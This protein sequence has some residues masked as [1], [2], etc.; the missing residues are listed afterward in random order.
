MLYIEYARKLPFTSGELVYMDDALPKPRLLAYTMY[1]F[2]FVFL[3]TSTAQCMNFARF[4]LAASKAEYRFGY[5]ELDNQQRL[6]R[7]MAVVAGTAVCV[8]LYV[9]NSKSRLVNKA[10]AGA[11]I[12]LLL[13]C[14]LAGATYVGERQLK[15]RMPG[16]NLGWQYTAPG[17]PNWPSAMITCLFS[18]H[19][20]EN[21]TLVGYTSPASP[22]FS[23]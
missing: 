3:Y 9:S 10:T 11:K 12:L 16:R 14:L 21:A 2:Y 1:T 18:Y 5:S 8:L 7:F 20:W 19:G 17:K 22:R 15:D 4:V 6:A 13:V 23:D